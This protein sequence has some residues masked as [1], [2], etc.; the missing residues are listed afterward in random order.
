LRVAGECVDEDGGD[1]EIGVSKRVDRTMDGQEGERP[2]PRTMTELGVEAKV[3]GGRAASPRAAR[4]ATSDAGDANGS[5][6]PAQGQGIWIPAQRDRAILKLAV[7]G[8]RVGR[9]TAARA[10]GGTTSQISD[11]ER[12]MGRWERR[13]AIS[14]LMYRR[15]RMGERWRERGKGRARRY[16]HVDPAYGCIQDGPDADPRTRM[17]MASA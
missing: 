1:L 11:T 3:S 12:V 17:R 13:L 14:G 9:G 16:A 6:I 15:S 5:R 2:G 4:K 8:S 10:R 7:C